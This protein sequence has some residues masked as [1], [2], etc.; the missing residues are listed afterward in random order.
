MATVSNPTPATLEEAVVL[1]GSLATEKRLLELRIQD[2][3]HRLYGSS[4]EK[5]PIEDRQ[6]ALIDE[7]FDNPEPATTEDVVVAPDIEKRTAKK[8]VRRPLPEHLE[9]V[10]ERL[11]PADKTC[12]HCGREQCLVREES[13]ERLDLI[14]ARLIRRRTVRPV[15]AC[16][17]CKDQSPVQVPMPP[18]VIDKGICGPGLLAHVVLAKYLQ[19]LPLYRVQQE[20][21]RF[22]VEITRTTLADWVAATATALE[23]LYHL[24]RDDLMAGSYLQV[25]ETPVQVMDPEVKGR[26]ATGWLWVYARPGGG[27]IF[28]FQK[29]RGRDGPDQMLKSFAGT[30]QSDGYG[31]Y[32]SLERDRSDLRRVACWAHARRKFHEA[33]PDDGP[34]SRG[35]IAMIAP[36]YGIEKVARESGLSPEA[37]KDLRNQHAPAML[38]RLHRR[39]LELNPARVGSPV[40]PKSPLGKAI[41][42]TLGQWEALV[43]YLEDGRYEIDTNLVENAIRPSCVGKNYAEIRIMRSTAAE[44]VMNGLDCSIDGWLRKG[45]VCAISQWVFAKHHDSKTIPSPLRSTPH[46]RQPSGHNPGA[47]RSRFADTRLCGVDCSVLRAGHRTFLPLAR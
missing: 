18:Q 37:R 4:S 9:V 38:E 34:R 26:T 36:L 12:S 23:P 31:L 11:E 47:V 28:D 13:S 35:I 30:F 40:L 24:V 3:E 7:V 20:I 14:P 21:A 25:D 29:G 22:G 46:G 33:I 27:V 32:E 1:L 43:R 16:S 19:H 44:L 45:G 2:L 17:A 5:L 6:L 10:E 42:Y 15:Y 8:P 39:L 41:R